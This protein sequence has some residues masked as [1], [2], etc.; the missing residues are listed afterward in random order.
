MPQL[1]IECLELSKYST[2]V[3][4]IL[5]FACFFK[6]T[7]LQ[8]NK[9]CIFGKHKLRSDFW[10]WFSKI[11]SCHLLFSEMSHNSQIKNSFNLIT[12]KCY[13]SKMTGVTKYNNNRSSYQEVGNPHIKTKREVEIWHLRKN[14][15]AS[16]KLRTNYYKG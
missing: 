6:N 8:T 12:L 14:Q 13:L 3:G 15:I 1:L 2:N 11:P 7:S 4:F 16:L 9:I 10:S 5:F